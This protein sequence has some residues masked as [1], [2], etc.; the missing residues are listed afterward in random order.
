MA[1]KDECKAC[2]NFVITRRITNVMRKDGKRETAA[3]YSCFAR[4]CPMPTL[5]RYDIP[6][7]PYY[8][9]GDNRLSYIVDELEVDANGVEVEKL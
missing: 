4:K 2:K 3:S 9:A 6:G 7:C 1:N 8:S 5:T